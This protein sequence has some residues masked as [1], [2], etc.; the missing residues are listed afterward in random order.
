M[1][2]SNA[3]F[4]SLTERDQS[5]LL[6]GLAAIMVFA[7]L[8]WVIFPS[9]EQR[10]KLQRQVTVKISEVV[11]MKQL[12]K[13][14]E[15]LRSS[16]ERNRSELQKRPSQFSLFSYLDALAGRTGLKDKIVYMKPTT[17]DE[18]GTQVR[19]SR[20]EMKLGKVTLD[21]VSRFLYHIEMSSNIIG[22]PRLALT[23]K[24][25]GEGGYLE[26]VVQVETPE[27]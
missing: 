2:Q 7:L 13:E 8:Q 14:Y 5:I 19:T 20:V 21:Q 3:I 17:L 23:Q 15:D 9:L 16:L 25:H 4:K 22:V 1:F 12:Q 24:N 10:R 6:A 26:A 18:N 11:Q 27:A